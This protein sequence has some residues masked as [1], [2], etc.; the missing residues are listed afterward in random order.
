MQHYYSNICAYVYKLQGDPNGNGEANVSDITIVVNYI[1]NEPAPPGPEDL[2]WSNWDVSSLPGYF[3]VFELPLNSGN[4]YGP[5]VIEGSPYWAAEVTGD[6]AIDVLDV[7][8]LNTCITNGGTSCNFLPRSFSIDGSASYSISAINED[9]SLNR[10]TGND[11]TL[12]ISSEVAVAGVQMDISFDASTLTFSGIEQ[13][14]VSSGL[15]LEYAMIDNGIVRFIL[16]PEADNII[17]AGD[18]EILTLQFDGLT[19]NINGVSDLQIM[20]PILAGA[21]GSKINIESVD[22]YPAKYSLHPAYPNPF[23]PTTTVGYE[24]P[25]DSQVSLVIYDMNGRVVSNLVSGHLFAGYYSVV[26]DASDYA[27]GLY[28]VKLTTPGYSATQ[29]LMLVK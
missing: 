6:G 11:L 28:F 10:S 17:P 1:I 18:H 14:D 19:R 27:S 25:V 4:V 2:P 20:N 22:N 12:S 21:G 5:Y 26:W 23:N 3:S 15:N 16:Y 7:V 13:T 8:A 9:P 29:K 24:L